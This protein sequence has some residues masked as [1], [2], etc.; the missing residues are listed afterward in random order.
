MM[1][2]LV[3]MAALMA[4]TVVAAPS[5]SSLGSSLNLLIDNDLQGKLPLASPPV[6]S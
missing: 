3:V 6:R 4:V 5:P 2:F 1:S